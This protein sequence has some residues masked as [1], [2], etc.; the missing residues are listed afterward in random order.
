MNIHPH[1]QS[2]DRDGKI[3]LEALQGW[4]AAS[5]NLPTWIQELEECVGEYQKLVQ[6]NNEEKASAT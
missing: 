6:A 2:I 4:A 3:T 5:D 1:Q